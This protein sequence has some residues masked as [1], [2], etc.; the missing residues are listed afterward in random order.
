MALVTNYLEIMFHEKD[1]LGNTDE[2]RSAQTNISRLKE[3]GVLQEIK[4]KTENLS[5]KIL[6]LS[7]QYENHVNIYHN[8]KLS[9][10]L[11]NQYTELLRHLHVDLKG[12]HGFITC[13]ENKTEVSYANVLYAIS[14]SLYISLDK[15]EEKRTIETLGIN[16]ADPIQQYLFLHKFI[17]DSYELKGIK[18]KLPPF[19][20]VVLHDFLMRPPAEVGNMALKDYKEHGEESKKFLKNYT[21]SIIKL[22]KESPDEMVEEYADILSTLFHQLGNPEKKCI[23]FSLYNVNDKHKRT[24]P[25]LKPENFNASSEFKKDLD[26]NDKLK[27]KYEAKVMKKFEEIK[28]LDK[29]LPG[30]MKYQR[31]AMEH[32]IDLFDTLK[33]EVTQQGFA[34][35]PVKREDVNL[36]Y[37]VGVDSQLQEVS[38]LM[39]SFLNG[40][41]IRIACLR[42]SPG[43]GKSMSVKGLTALKN[44]KTVMADSNC[45]N[46]YLEPMLDMFKRKDYPLVLYVDNYEMNGGIKWETMSRVIDGF[47]EFPKNLMILLST[48][49]SFNSNAFGRYVLGKAPQNIEDRINFIDYSF[50][51]RKFKDPL[52]KAFCEKHNIKFKDSYIRKVH[53]KS[54]KRRK[55]LSNKFKPNK[56]RSPRKLEQFFL[57]AVREEKYLK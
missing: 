27:L 52:I 18:T 28:D 9:I 36:D 20:Y 43:V 24:I 49:E 22:S 34:L 17:V 21:K 38:T 41:D 8:K 3:E 19:T 4:E 30:V 47:E 26:S 1:A 11:L 33:V 55:G 35:R 44:V 10:P 31:M 48:N 39:E 29:V 25:S 14:K 46:T 6:S 40:D 12:I 7:Q 37:M 56:N 13:L 15:N 53:E 45:L 23:S 16:Q 2:V 50:N 5:Q 51:Y 54:K 57:Q 32:F 42:G